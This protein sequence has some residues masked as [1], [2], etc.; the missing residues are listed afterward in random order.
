MF[1]NSVLT[2]TK[3]EQAGVSLIIIDKFSSDVDHIW[4]GTRW[5]CRHRRLNNVDIL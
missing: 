2:V 4:H 5:G 3:D 1:Q